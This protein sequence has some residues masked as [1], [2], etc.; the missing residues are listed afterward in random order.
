MS[1]APTTFEGDVTAWGLGYHLDHVGIQ[2]P[3]YLW[4]HSDLRGF[5]L[6]LGAMVTNWTQVAAAGCVWVH[7]SDAS[8]VCADVCCPCYH[9]DPCEPRVEAQDCAEL[10]LHLPGTG[11]VD[12]PTGYLILPALFPP[13]I[14]SSLPT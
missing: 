6:P 11:R 3:H 8:R 13:L 12:S 4:A 10:V 9:R 5:A 7:G 14:E 2:R 1:L